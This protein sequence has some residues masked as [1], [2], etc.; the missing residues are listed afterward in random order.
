MALRSLA[1]CLLMVLVS[2]VALAPG[3][4]EGSSRK[5]LAQ[6]NAAV[7]AQAYGICNAL[8]T[9]HGYRCQE[10][11]VTTDD[12]YILSVQRIGGGGT[13]KPP[14]IIQH[15]V[16]VDA[17]VWLMNS[18]DKNLPLILADSGFDV[19]MANTRGTRFSRRHTSMDPSDPKFWN[20]SWDELVA[21]DLPAV[22]NYVHGQTKQKINYVGHSLGTLLALASLSEGKLVDQLKSV[23]LLTPIAYL[24]HMSTPIC[25]VGARLF[26]GEIITA[27]RFAEFD[28]KGEPVAEF[29]DHL[30]ATPG[31]PCYDIFSLLTGKNCCLNAS[32]V[33]LFLDHQ[34]QSTSTKNLVHL[35]QVVRNGILTKYDHGRSYTN[36][37]HYGSF[38]APHYDLSKIPNHLPMFITYGGQDALSDE[39][40]VLHLL[41]HF[42]SH[43]A[44]KLVVDFIPEYAHF[45]F[46]AG[47]NA[48]DLV[49]NKVISFFNQQQ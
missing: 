11:T 49:Y 16:L 7:A 26:A 22:F 13:G 9:V 27:F 1:F 14:V 28:P 34:P 39:L 8:V 21:H 2:V 37:M 44:G 17:A 41:D 29:L 18:P 25:A 31:V 36:Y 19:W 33:D 35:S 45:D 38:F 24:T 42:K 23:A 4:V 40:D 32:T 47:I 48:K 46:V 3:A 5:L 30:C 43:D 15:G 6:A 20:W 12:G 10:I